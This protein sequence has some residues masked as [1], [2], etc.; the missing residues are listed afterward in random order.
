MASS[1][2]VKNSKE[3]KAFSASEVVRHRLKEDLYIVIHDKV[4]DV[5]SFIDNHPQ[6]SSLVLTVIDGVWKLLTNRTEVGRKCLLTREVMTLQKLS[7]R[8]DIARMHNSSSPIS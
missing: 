7:W 6:V 3:M 1:P 8:L 5:T 2:N 4:Y